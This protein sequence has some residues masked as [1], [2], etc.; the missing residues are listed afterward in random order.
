MR[1]ELHCF[2]A[3]GRV[4]GIIEPDDVDLWLAEEADAFFAEGGECEL[5]DAT[6]GVRV[7]DAPLTSGEAVWLAIAQ[8]Q[9]ADAEA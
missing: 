4:A 2:D 3:D 1:V 5:W 6:R 8:A 9:A 7:V